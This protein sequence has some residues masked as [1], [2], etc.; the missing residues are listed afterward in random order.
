MVTYKCKTCGGEMD[1]CGTDGFICQYCGSKAFLSD[2]DYKDNEKFR[3]LLL[4]YNRSLAENKELDYSTDHFWTYRD[5]D[6]YPMEDGRPLRIEYMKKYER[7]GYTCYIAKESVVYVFGS[8]TEADAFSQ[9]LDRLRFPASD[10]KLQR[11]FPELKMEIGLQTGGKAHAYLRRPNCYPAGMF[12]PWASAHLAWVISRMENICCALEF[13][14]IEHGDI[15]PDSVW[16]N[17]LTHEGMLFG[18][19]RK[20]GGKR[21]RA[22]LN[23]LRKT[24]I[25]LAKNTGEPKEL[26][27]FLNSPP[28]QDAY[29]DFEK[30]DRVIED[31][32]GGHRFIK[33][34]F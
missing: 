32:F 1:F 7:D 4:Q 23:A 6:V 13:S 20:V 30:W 28:A 31:G 29:A 9:G 2:E 22:D 14:G 17:P 26:Y 11:V 25:A 12:A 24:A 15:A 33:M 21:S 34:E 19:W 18:D 10:D 5:V 27:R 16:V 3:E 8:Q